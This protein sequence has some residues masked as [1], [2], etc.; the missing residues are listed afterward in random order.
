MGWK[1]FDRVREDHQQVRVRQGG[2]AVGGACLYL[3]Y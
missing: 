2:F 3:L 1:G